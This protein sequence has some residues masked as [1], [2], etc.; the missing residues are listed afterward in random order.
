MTL[1]IVGLRYKTIEAEDALIAALKVKHAKPDA[2]IGLN[3][4]AAALL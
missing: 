2:T 3:S 1:Y 4:R